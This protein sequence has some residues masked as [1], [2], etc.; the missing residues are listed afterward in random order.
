M[1]ETMKIMI[2]LM[3]ILRIKNDADVNYNQTKKNI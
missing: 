3:E 1:L 2:V